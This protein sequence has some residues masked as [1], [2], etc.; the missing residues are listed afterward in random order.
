MRPVEGSNPD[1]SSREQAAEEKAR[2]E[3]IEQKAICDRGDRA[4]FFSS[5]STLSLSPSLSSSL[6]LRVLLCKEG[7]S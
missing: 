1:C 3:R 6:S 2:E 5:T 4:F 7:A